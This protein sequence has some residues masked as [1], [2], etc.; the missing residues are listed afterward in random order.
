MFELKMK[1]LNFD[2][3]K[4]EKSKCKKWMLGN[5]VLYDLCKKYPLHNNDEEIRAKIWL[6]GRSYA[7]SIERRRSKNHINDDFYDYVTKEFINFNKKENFDKEL[8]EI[9]KLNFNDK[10]LNKILELHNKLTIFFKKLTGLE[11][12]SLASKYLHFHA[13]I[14]PIYDSRAKDSLNKIIKGQI[15][16]KGDKEYSR[17]CNKI[18]FLFNEIKKE[19]N[20]EP[21]IREIDT[22]LVKIANENLNK[23]N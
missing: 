14:F 21:T 19:T 9:K 11:K 6:I 5:N 20:K 4:F 1:K 16:T 7:A 13:P 10:S 3:N 17:F 12:R 22:Y 23:K 8:N 15:F 2:I 18:L